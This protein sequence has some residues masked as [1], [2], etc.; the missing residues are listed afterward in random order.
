MNNVSIRAQDQLSIFFTEI[1][2]FSQ[3]S[4]LNA[5]RCMQTA[6]LGDSRFF[7]HKVVGNKRDVNPHPSDQTYFMVFA[8]LTRREFFLRLSILIS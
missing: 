6:I 2:I 4:S 1:P 7:K 5:H 8:K 3:F